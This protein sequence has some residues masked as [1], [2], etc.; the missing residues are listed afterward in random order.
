MTKPHYMR[1]ITPLSY[2][3]C[4]NLT[5]TGL[6][7]LDGFLRFRDSRSLLALEQSF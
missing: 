7:I 4:S 2:Y 5:V 3:Y 6:Y 1:W